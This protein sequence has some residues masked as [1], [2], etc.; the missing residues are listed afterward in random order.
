MIEV[1]DIAVRKRWDGMVIPLKVYTTLID[2]S[3]NMD[4]DEREEFWFEAHENQGIKYNPNKHV[5][6]DF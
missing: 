5:I 1:V 2:M 4:E 3:F 6:V